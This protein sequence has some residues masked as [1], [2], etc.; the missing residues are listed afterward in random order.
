MSKTTRHYSGKRSK[1]FW[2]RVNALPESSSSTLYYSGVLLQDMEWR[3]LKWLE[4]A[5]DERDQRHAGKA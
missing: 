2:S 4:L 5:E 3:V 1:R